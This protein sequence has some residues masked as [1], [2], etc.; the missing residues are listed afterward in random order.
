VYLRIRGLAT[1]NLFFIIAFPVWNNRVFSLFFMRA[2]IIEVIN[3][4][5]AFIVARN[6]IFLNGFSRDCS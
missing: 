6:E 1:E 2:T 3:Y 4:L 5:M